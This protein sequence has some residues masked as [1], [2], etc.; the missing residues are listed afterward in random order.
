MFHYKASSYRG[1]PILGN[2]L[3]IDVNAV[4]KN[5]DRNDIQQYNHFASFS[6]I[7]GTTNEE[8]M[9]MSKTWEI[10]I[11]SS[12]SLSSGVPPLMDTR[13]ISQTLILFHDFVPESC[14]FHF[15]IVRRNPYC[16]DFRKMQVQIQSQIGLRRPGVMMLVPSALWAEIAGHFVNSLLGQNCIEQYWTS[17]NAKRMERMVLVL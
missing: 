4:N 12:S 9:G 1:T 5:I 6:H 16:Q 13:G 8:S 2:L 3:E 11:D 15:H 17:W 14:W 10:P 7:S